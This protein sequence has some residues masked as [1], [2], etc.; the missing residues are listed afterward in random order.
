MDVRVRAFAVFREV[1]EKEVEVTLPEKATISDLLADLSQ[2]YPGFQ[3]MA[4]EKPGV[5]HKF[6]N[7]L[8]NGRNIEFLLRLDT[9]LAGGDVISL[10]P[11]VGGG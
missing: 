4:F 10:F 6:V 9:P 11:P 1:L 5:L 8:L 2:R 3:E 7:I